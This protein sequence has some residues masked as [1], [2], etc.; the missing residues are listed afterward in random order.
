MTGNLC[1]CGTYLRIRAGDSPR[2]R[3][4]TH[5]Q[6]ERRRQR[7]AA[8]KEETMA[9]QCLNRRSFLRVTALAGGGL[10]LACYLDPAECSRRAG[11]GGA[12]CVAERLHHASRRTASSPS[13][14]K[15]PEIGQGIKTMLPMLIAEELDVDWKN[16]QHRAGRL[17]SA[18]STAARPPAA[19]PRR[20]PTGRRCARSARPDAQM[21]VA[22]AA[23]TWNVPEAECTTASG[24]VMH[25]AIESIPRLRRTRREGGDA[26]AAR[27][28]DGQAQGPEGLQDHRQ[29]THGRRQRGDRHRQAA[30]RHRLHA[31]GHAVRRV[32][33]VSGVRRQGRSA[34][35][36]EIKAMPGVRHA[37]IVEGGTRT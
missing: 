33:E 32:R 10:M 12:A 4:P 29:A 11:R 21:L 1:R 22:A 27:S 36:D 19:A 17:R 30:L 16:V 37:F 7:G 5:R 34:N 25:A 35:L 13:S 14:A 2:G 3:V 15:N 8:S 26:S 9:T 23:Q 20:R 24:Q 18:R 6:A 28:R 31:A